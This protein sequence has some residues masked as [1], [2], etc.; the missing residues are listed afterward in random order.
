MS[1]S[2]YKS[3]IPVIALLLIDAALLAVWIYL[4]I[5]IDNR[6]VAANDLKQQIKAAELRIEGR[7]DLKKLVEDATDKK[8]IIDGVFLNSNSLVTLVEQLEAAGRSAGVAVN[9]T[10]ADSPTGA[11]SRPSFK[12]SVGG[13]L[14]KVFRF[15]M[16][17]ENLP[18]R[19]DVTNAVWTEQGAVGGQ[20][21]S[22]QVNFD[23]I[24]ISYEAAG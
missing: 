20:P 17:L 23:I 4:P 10:S 6:I 21:A 3:I 9:I 11:V 12:L 24:L 16:L 19:V 7:H 13:E 2:K 14:S 1:L 8:K 18:N 22:W 5:S 15:L